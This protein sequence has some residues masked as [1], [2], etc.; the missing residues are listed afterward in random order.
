MKK[1]AKEIKNIYDFFYKEHIK[2]WFEENRL[3]KFPAFKYRLNKFFWFDWK[4]YIEKAEEV[5]RDLKKSFWFYNS[6]SKNWNWEVYPIIK[7]DYVRI[8]NKSKR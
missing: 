2:I 4:S 3:I 7:I 8:T 1:E 5:A 6:L